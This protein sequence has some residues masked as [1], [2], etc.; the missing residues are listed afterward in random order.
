MSTKKTRFDRAKVAKRVRLARHAIDRFLLD[1][2][3]QL[4]PGTLLL[5]GGAGNCKHRQFF[6]NVNIIALDLTPRR[7]RRYGEIDLAA[8]LY[9]LPFRDNVFEVVLNVEVLEHLKEP[10]V[11]LAEIFRVLRPQ[12]RLFLIAPQAWEEHN[13]PRDYFRFTSHGL[14]YLFETVGFEVLSIQ[15]LG[16][17]FFYLGHA[18][19]SS[20]RYFFPTNRKAL[21]KFLDAPIRHPS[22][23]L[24][25]VIVPY[26]CFYLDRLDDRRTFTLNYGC[27]CRKP[28]SL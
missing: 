19:S 15:P 4:A 6:P 9:D 20:Y 8:D 14:R 2:A 13:V 10:K 24:L 1:V 7:V 28:K 12:G 5:D 25:R 23:L 16:G 3:G 18:V 11:V 26:L 27:V 21:W 17:F 22:R